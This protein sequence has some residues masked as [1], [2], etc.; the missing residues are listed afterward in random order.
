MD[1]LRK[2]VG[3]LYGEDIPLDRTLLLEWLISKLEAWGSSAGM[4]SFK[5]DE[6]DGRIAVTLGGK[7]I[8]IDVNLLVDRTDIHVPRISLASVKTS[9][10]VLN[11]T[12]G[13]TTSG[14][15]SLDG[16]LSDCLRAFLTQVQLDEEE[17]NPEEVARTTTRI[18][19]DLKYVMKLDQLALREGEQGLRWFHN[20][21]TLS[22]QAEDVAAR[23]AESVARYRITC[24][25]NESTCNVY[26]NSQVCLV[27][28]GAP[29]HLPHA[30]PCPS[31]TLRRHSFNLLPRLPLTARIS[32][33]SAYMS[34]ERAAT[35]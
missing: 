26:T 17:Q 35:I 13:G 21:D 29:R 23:E 2:R 31:A 8:V 6:T 28:G 33:S 22:A 14:S 32:D 25:G 30:G 10:A 12:S 15:I 34:A 18:S 3:I 24:F 11:G 16:F 20:M 5:E 27:S 9:Y 4:E 1:I 19:D 7:V